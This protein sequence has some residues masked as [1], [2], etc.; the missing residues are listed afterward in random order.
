MDSPHTVLEP[1][2]KSLF[3]NTDLDDIGEVR[4]VRKC[5]L[6]V[7]A[8]NLMTSNTRTL[9]AIIGTDDHTEHI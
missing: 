2:C 3:R 7:P 5:L 9:L 1:Y 6:A 4:K 8:F